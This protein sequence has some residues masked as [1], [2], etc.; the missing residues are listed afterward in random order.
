MTSSKKIAANRSNA[1]RSVGP[2][3]AQ[4][5]MRARM[6]A[7]SHGLSAPARLDAATSAEIERLARWICGDSPTPAQYEYARAIA[8]EQIMLRRVE[9]AYVA[10]IENATRTAHAAADPHQANLGVA[11]RRETRTAAPVLREMSLE[12]LGVALPQLVILERYKQRALA[13]RQRAMQGFV[14]ASA[15]PHCAKSEDTKAAD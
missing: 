6:N 8:E 4:G 14:S 2:K 3:T 9:T 7:L 5:K 11:V 1:A 10:I 15:F 13:R 12:A